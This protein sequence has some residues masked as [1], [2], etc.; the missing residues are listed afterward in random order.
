MQPTQKEPRLAGP[1]GGP[2]VLFDGS[3]IIEFLQPEPQLDASF[4]FRATYKGDHELMKLGKSH[5]QAP[6]LHIHFAQSESFLV[7]A[8]AVGTTTTYNLID[9]VHTPSASYNQV[10]PPSG[11]S[12]PI[13]SRNASGEV[14]IPPWTPHNFWP[15]A[16][17]HPFWSTPEGKEYESSLPH[18]RNSDTTVLIWGYPKNSTGSPTGT[19][20]TDFPPDMDAAFFLALLGLVDA[21]SSS[22]VAMT[23]K[24]FATLFSMQTA[25]ELGVIVAPTA[26]WLGPL[27]WRVPWA[28]QVILEKV[29]L[30]LG[31]NHPAKVVEDVIQD[32]VVKRQ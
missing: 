12:P 1:L 32:I 24:V 17:T 5:P 3:F 18:G 11:L 19:L 10:T 2:H 13:P 20:T 8:G 21:L 4:L 25:S 28:A 26:W 7:T 29:R 22:R 9:T 27:R 14:A 6:P 30:L 16:P 23:P 31:G 15:V